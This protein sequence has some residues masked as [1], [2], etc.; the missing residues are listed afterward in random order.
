MSCCIRGTWYSRQLMVDV[1][2]V[3]SGGGISVTLRDRGSG[4]LRPTPSPVSVAV[5]AQ[6]Y[7]NQE[8]KNGT[9]YRAHRG[10]LQQGVIR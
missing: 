10:V 7:Q 1:I 8:A 3:V 9:S 4:A 6:G 5:N 2:V